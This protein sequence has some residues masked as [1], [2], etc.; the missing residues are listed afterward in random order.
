MRSVLLQILPSFMR[1]TERL[2]TRLVHE[3]GDNRGPDHSSGEV[4]VAA[5]GIMDVTEAFLRVICNPSSGDRD[6]RNI[7]FAAIAGA[8][9]CTLAAVPRVF[10]NPLVSCIPSFCCGCRLKVGNPPGASTHDCG[11]SKQ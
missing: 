5:S 7:M 3:W 11:T 10:P 1:Y 9:L 6:A 8:V 2:A 4:A